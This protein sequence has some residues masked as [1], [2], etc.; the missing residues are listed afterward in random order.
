MIVVFEEMRKM[1]Y[2]KLKEIQE[3]E[4]KILEKTI[5]FLEQNNI[6]YAICGGTML[7][8]VRHKG[9]IPWDDD[10]DL[11]IPR[12]DYE[13]LIEVLNKN[14]Q[15]IDQYHA[16]SVLLKNDFCP[17]IKVINKKIFTHSERLTNNRQ[18]NLWID[19]FPLDGLP[20]DDME[21]KKQYDKIK[22]Y[23][24]LYL[25]KGYKYSY[26]FK[27]SSITKMIPKIIIKTFLLCIPDSILSKKLDSLSK[28][29]PYDQANYIGGV[30]WG[31]GPKEKMLKSEVSFTDF[32]FCD[33][34][35][36]GLANYDLY[37]TNLYGD[38]RKLPPKEK[39]KTHNF[40]AWRS[41]K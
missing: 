20:D 39:R 38:Y 8:A 10:I 6:Q 1:Q 11:L 9:F 25:L 40:E 30:L 7:G 15:K 17:F 16:V 36:K 35:V 34:K 22:K 41:A 31:Y 4:K 23:K 37:L 5:D 28:K 33:L 14:D 26:I 2:L 13:R 29:Y 19:I 24:K 3:E 12:P 27:V 32:D 18:T 21:T